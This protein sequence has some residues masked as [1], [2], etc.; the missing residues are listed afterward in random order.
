LC[1]RA[2][3]GIAVMR[4]GKAEGPDQ[5]NE[6]APGDQVLA[7]LRRGKEDDLRKLLLSR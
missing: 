1:P 3:V 2:G 5:A 4:D 7:V 6:L